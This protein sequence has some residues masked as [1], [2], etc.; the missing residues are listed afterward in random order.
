MTALSLYPHPWELT[1]GQLDDAR[2][3]VQEMGKFDSATH[4]FGGELTI[5]DKAAVSVALA[6]DNLFGIVPLIPK[7]QSD[8]L[9]WA[10]VCSFAMWG[11][12]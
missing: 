10:Y 1:P 6:L 5:D 3:A 4:E 12:R 2:H 7:H 9:L 11:E 8:A